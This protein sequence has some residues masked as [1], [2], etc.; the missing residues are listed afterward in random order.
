M[1]QGGL[2]NLTE[3]PYQWTLMAVGVRHHFGGV[4]Y[5]YTPAEHV[6]DTLHVVVP[7]VWRGRRALSC[8]VKK[9]P[10]V[11]LELQPRVGA[12]PKNSTSAICRNS[13]LYGCARVRES[14]AIFRPF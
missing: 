9:I 5:V 7:R 10:L 6:L 1:R 11:T 3:P 14:R 4:R 12:P 2:S 8:R 13:D